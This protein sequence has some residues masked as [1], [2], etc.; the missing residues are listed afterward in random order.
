MPDLTRYFKDKAT[1]KALSYDVNDPLGEFG[2]FGT[3][4][5]GFGTDPLG[6]FGNTAKNLK[7]DTAI[8]VQGGINPDIG[9]IPDALQARSVVPVDTSRLGKKIANP[10]DKGRLTYTKFRN[11]EPNVLHKFSSFNTIV[12][13]YALSVEENN[14]P[15]RIVGKKNGLQLIAR[16]GGSADA[17][18]VPTLDRN[19]NKREFFIQDLELESIPAGSPKS[20]NA[21]VIKLNFKVYEPY[22]LGGFLETLRQ[23]AKV[24]KHKNYTQA[25]YLLHVKYKGYDSEGKIMPS[26]NLPDSNLICKIVN[27]EFSV[28]QGGSMYAVE[29]IPFNHQALNRSAQQINTEITLQGT[30]VV[31]MLQGNAKSLQEVL[32]KKK[33]EQKIKPAGN[34]SK[35][36]TAEQK[37]SREA[38]EEKEKNQ[39]QLDDF[40]IN[41]PEATALAAKNR[42]DLEKSNKNTGSVD[43]DKLRSELLATGAEVRSASNSFQYKQKLETVNPIGKFKLNLTKDQ[44]GQV[45]EQFFTND[46]NKKIRK[47]DQDFR[48]LRSS[49][50]TFPQGSS[51]ENIISTVIQYSE[52]GVEALKILEDK[53]D[54]GTIQWF[55]IFTQVFIIPDEKIFAEYG[56]YPNLYVYN[57]LPYRVMASIFAKPNDAPIVPEKFLQDN[58]NKEYDYLYTGKNLDVIDFAIDF[59]FSY[60]ATIP[61]DGVKGKRLSGDVEKENSDSSATAKQ[62]KNDGTTN[63]NDQ[64]IA[65]SVTPGTVMRRPIMGIT[66]GVNNLTDAQ[67]ISM[68]LQDA[69]MHSSADLLNVNLTI[70]GDPYWV[71][72]NGVGNYFAPASAPTNDVKTRTGTVRSMLKPPVIVINFRTPLDIDESTGEAIFR[73]QKTKGENYTLVPQFSG[74]YRVT[75]MMNT[76]QGGMFKTTLDCVRV[77]NQ[78]VKKKSDAKKSQT[79]YGTKDVEPPPN[80]SEVDDGL[81]NVLGND[82]SPRITKRIR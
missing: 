21:T 15:A 36:E 71:G 49:R 66:E 14:R 69:L 20:K 16:S 77:I 82:V 7:L 22:S 56:R 17:F 40:V 27:V 26:D 64:S 63:S 73:D 74:V 18:K 13:L 38:A 39:I 50:L 51:I 57:V 79:I 3:D 1:E 52:C 67:R 12:S 75:R 53:S 24:L 23:S 2:K 9:G 31:E 54:L 80:F 60:F 68:E 72:D 33:K 78:E 19:N 25:P 8:T 10:Q 62:N 30:T 34:I 70:L 76:W 37:K 43:V 44:V 6:E 81:K 46:E 59:K 28:S 65:G 58:V 4:N 41:F 35:K 29:A 11:V 42:R 47:T 5:P 48:D 32:N 55:T 61:S 45:A